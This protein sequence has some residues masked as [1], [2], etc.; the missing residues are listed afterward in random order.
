MRLSAAYG[1]HYGFRHFGD[2]PTLQSGSSGSAVVALQQ[3]LGTLG[4]A[5]DVDGQFGPDTQG[6]LEN[7]QNDNGIPVTGVADAATWASI[8]GSPL[9]AITIPQSNAPLA[10]P[11]ITSL[12]AVPLVPATATPTGGGITLPTDWKVWAAVGA[13]GLGAVV[14]AWGVSSHFKN[15][16][17]LAA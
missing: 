16:R 13:F 7:Y 6:A 15:G 8:S 17:T 1:N 12:T 9:T 10:T 5:I 11:A 14:L 3:D 2:P 4:Y